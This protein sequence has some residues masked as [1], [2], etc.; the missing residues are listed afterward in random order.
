LGRCPHEYENKAGAKRYLDAINLSKDETGAFYASPKGKLVGVMT[1]QTVAHLTDE[2]CAAA[3]WRAL[4]T[5][6]KEPGP[7]ASST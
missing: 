1:K 6:T 5:L 7:D 4:Q 2:S 3:C